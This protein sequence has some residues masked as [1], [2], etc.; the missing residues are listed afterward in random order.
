M[1]Q[2]TLTKTL[3]LE[4]CNICRSIDLITL[5]IK[6]NVGNNTRFINF[7]ECLAFKTAFNA[8]AF[9]L[10]AKQ[11]LYALIYVPEKNFYLL[12]DVYN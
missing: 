9:V 12:L 11:K 7:A 8:S 1:S 10:G 2:P 6:S 5:I 4:I 3:R